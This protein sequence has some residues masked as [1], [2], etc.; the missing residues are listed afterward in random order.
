MEQSRLQTTTP[1]QYYEL[2]KNGGSGQLFYLIEGKGKDE[3]VFDSV[4]VDT[5]KKDETIN[6]LTRVSKLPGFIGF[7]GTYEFNK[8]IEE[9]F[10]DLE[11]SK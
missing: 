1:E 6:R 10:A 9:G 5:A 11:N 8:F 7:P 2:I 4:I 3:Y